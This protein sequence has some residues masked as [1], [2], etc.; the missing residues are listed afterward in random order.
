MS[1]ESKNA[2]PAPAEPKEVAPTVIEKTN[3][4]MTPELA[5]FIEARANE[6]VASVVQ[7]KEK[8]FI[9]FQEKFKEDFNKE[10]EQIKLAEEKNLLVEKINKDEN[11]KKKFDDFQLNAEE[12]DNVNLSKYMEIFSGELN[13]NTAQPVGQPFQTSGTF[14]IYAEAK[15][16]FA[17]A[18]AKRRK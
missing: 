10:Q 17:D 5:A 16:G 11:L 7:E 15:K 18:D 3:I 6:K 12:L 9:S 2:T 8:E 1:D 14:D 13:K 4:T